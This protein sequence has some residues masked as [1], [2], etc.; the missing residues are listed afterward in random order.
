MKRLKVYPKSI[1]ASTNA[2]KDDEIVNAS[3]GTSK[4][5][6]KSANSSEDLLDQ[7]C[8]I[9]K[10]DYYWGGEGLDAVY[11]YLDGMDN[12]TENDLR[13]AMDSAADMMGLDRDELI[14][15]YTEDKRMAHEVAERLGIS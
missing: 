15:A 4:K 8:N 10:E 14:D 7:I 1:K 11:Y 2:P 9:L 3:C 5:Y 6:V 13:Y 12:I